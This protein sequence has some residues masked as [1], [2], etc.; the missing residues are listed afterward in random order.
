MTD[1]QLEM[2]RNHVKLVT[3]HYIFLFSGYARD[4]VIFKKNL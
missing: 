2:G 3:G 4:G 1:D